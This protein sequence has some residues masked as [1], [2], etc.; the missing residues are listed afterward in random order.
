MKTKGVAPSMSREEFLETLLGFE[1]GPQMEF[2][3]LGKLERPLETIVAFANT[4]GGFLVLGLED[5][6]KASG[7]DRLYGIEENPEALDELRRL[8]RQRVT[9]ALTSPAVDE[10][11]FT[12]VP[13]TLRTGKPGRLVIVQVHPSPTVHS[14]V[15]GATLARVGRSNRQLTA[16]EITNL[17]L[18]RGTRSVVDDPVSVP[19]DLLDT[20]TWRQ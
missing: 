11:E 8:L 18:Q 5:P 4:E 16:A 10:P 12:D 17:S 14:L 9:P 15:D 7:H 1:E 6:K 2:K 13:C 3:R 20:A 19:F